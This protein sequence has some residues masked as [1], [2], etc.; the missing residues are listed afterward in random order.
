MWRNHHTLKN[1]WLSGKYRQKCLELFLEKNAVHREKSNCIALCH[2]LWRRS[3]VSISVK[4][5]RERNLLHVLLLLIGRTSFLAEEKSMQWIT[6]GDIGFFFDF[7]RAS[8][9]FYLS[10]GVYPHLLLLLLRLLLP[11][12]SSSSCIPHLF[13]AFL[14]YFF[15]TSSAQSF[16]EF[17]SSFSFETWTSPRKS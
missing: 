16:L 10:R 4:K 3:K 9:L 13:F 15:Y 12:H 2:E 17:S 5:K 1:R 8:R 7:P 11:L 14:Q 6:L